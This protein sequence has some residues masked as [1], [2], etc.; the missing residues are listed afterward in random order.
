MALAPLVAS[1][2]PVLLNAGFFGGHYYQVYSAAGIEWPAADS[3]AKGKSFTYQGKVIPGHLATLTSKSEDDFV[4]SLR[5]ASAVSP[6]EVWVGGFQTACATVSPRCGWA[7]INDEGAIAGVNNALTFANWR[8][9]EPNDSGGDEKYLGI[10]LGGPG[11]NDERAL[12]NIG[13]FVVEYDVPINAADCATPG[14]CETTTGQTLTLP[15]TPPAGATIGVKTYTFTDD[16]S[17]C[18]KTPLSLFDG[19][20]VIPSYLCGSPQFLVVKTEPNFDVPSGTVEIE[21]DTADIFPANTANECASPITGDPKHQAVVVW[22]ATDSSEMHEKNFP[23]TS[24]YLPGIGYAGE[25]TDGCGSSRGSVRGGSYHVIGMHI[26]FLS[27]EP[28]FVFGGYVALTSYKFQLLRVAIDAA[29]NANAITQ[30]K[31]NELKGTADAAAG[32]FGS[33]HYAASLNLLKVLDQKLQKITITP[34][35]FNHEGDLEMRTRN[36]IFMI[37]AKVLPLSQ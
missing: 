13:G 29:K 11:W 23:T 4:E 26:G 24:G 12:G 30:G 35:P 1:A 33:A 6:G 20:L 18:G 36:L 22:Q 15:A 3:A 17:R 10:G 31:Y 27:D 7:W 32:Q 8:V 21:N 37:Q 28:A 14:G 34:Q 2:T 16:P 9:G 25:F 19:A 5:V